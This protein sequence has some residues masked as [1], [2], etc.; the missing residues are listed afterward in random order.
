MIIRRSAAELEKMRRAGLL[1]WEILHRLKG[2]VGEGVTTLDLEVV[3][4]RMIADAGAKPAFKGY[5][6]PAV[7]QKFPFVLC[8]S[9]NEEIVHGV[10]GDRR[11]V[12]GDL[13]KLDV[14]AELDG[15]FADACE[16]VPVPPVT[17]LRARSTR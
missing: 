10:P 16:T 5:F 8:T 1:V 15:Y 2:M 4:E 7:G 11:L 14:T 12:R 9:V 13:V 17:R 3:A 6:V